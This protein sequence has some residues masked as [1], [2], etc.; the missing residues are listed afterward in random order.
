MEK[1]TDILH[2]LETHQIVLF[3]IGALLILGLFLMVGY[4]K[5]RRSER[6]NKSK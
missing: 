4:W 6:R 5:G 3:L 2:L 1:E